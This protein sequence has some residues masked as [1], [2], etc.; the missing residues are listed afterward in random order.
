MNLDGDYP[1][2]RFLDFVQQWLD[3]SF[4]TVSKFTKDVYVI[5]LRGQALPKQQTSYSAILITDSH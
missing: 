2:S 1:W 3:S 5:E 4:L